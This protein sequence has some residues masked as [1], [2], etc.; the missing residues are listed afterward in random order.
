MA[1]MDLKAAEDES[2]PNSTDA[3]RRSSR[4][5]QTF[6]HF[7]LIMLSTMLGASLAYSLGQDINFDQL[8][9]HAYVADAFWT[10]RAGRDVAPAQIIHSFFSPLIY[11]PF[12]LMIKYFSPDVVGTILG[13]GHGL[14]LWLVAV[15]AWIVTPTLRLMERLPTVVAAVVISAASPMAISEIGTTLSDLLTSVL[16]L[17]GLAL[18]MRAEFQSARAM[19]T[20]IWIGLAG[21][22]VGAAVSLKL[23]NASFAV[24]LFAATTVGWRNWSDRLTAI[25]AICAGGC[26]GFAACGGFWYLQMWRMFRNPFFPYYNAI[27]RSPDYPSAS[28]VFDARFLPHDL[29]EALSYPFHWAISE[30]MTVE[31]PS[32]DIRFAVFIVAGLVAIGVRLA[33]WPEASMRWTPAGKRLAVFFV[34]AFCLWMYEWSIQRYI[35]VLELLLGPALLLV[36]QRC[37]FGRYGR[38]F[39]LPCVTAVL[40]AACAVTVKAPDWGRLPWAK[41]WYS[42]NVPTVVGDHPIV[43]LDGEP[44]SYLVLGLPPAS[45]AI[46][47]I[48]WEDIPS[49]GDS[50]F[51]RRIKDLLADPHNEVLQAVAAGPLS[52]AFKK[53]IARY[54]LSPNGD[55]ITTAGR[56]VPLTWCPLIRTAPR[57]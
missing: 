18:L 47:V 6:L 21:V 52:D 10:N 7:I 24:A 35:V 12:Y 20:S 29:R 48:A 2:L 50:E 55:C 36:L 44:L 33:R 54:G 32:R 13:A 22:L 39:L 27:F 45:T 23:T 8:N 5:K 56:P 53:S 40:A 43:F 34:I 25:A 38:G 49:M 31:R 17:G 3:L 41:T 26:L 15:I 14:N 37:G 11:L 46:E 51:L 1:P 28:S 19:S 57:G 30:Q 9:Y 4:G 42:I 16:V